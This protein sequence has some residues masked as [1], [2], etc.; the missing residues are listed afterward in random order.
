MLKRVNKNISIEKVKNVEKNSIYYTFNVYIFILIIFDFVKNNNTILG[1]RP[2]AN[3]Y[4]KSYSAAI[5][6]VLKNYDKSIIE[7]RNVKFNKKLS[8]WPIR[9]EDNVRLYNVTVT[10]IDDFIRNV[11]K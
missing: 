2:M 9:L 3:T 6:Y 1:Y 5:D 7:P 10:I 4:R 11:K 8:A